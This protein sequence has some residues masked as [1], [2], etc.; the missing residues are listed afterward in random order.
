MQLELVEHLF[1]IVIQFGN[2]AQ[3][4]LSAIDRWQNDIYAVHSG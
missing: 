3:P 4:Y 2:A 1:L